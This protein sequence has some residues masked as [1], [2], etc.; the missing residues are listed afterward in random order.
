MTLRRSIMVAIL[1]VVALLAA[2]LLWPRLAPQSRSQTPKSPP[3][4]PVTVAQ[5]T[6]KTVPVRLAGREVDPRQ[7]LH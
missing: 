2:T 5:V 6:T 4:G 7:R 1:L 3:A